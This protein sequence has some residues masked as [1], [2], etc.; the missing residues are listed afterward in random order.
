[1]GEERKERRS[2]LLGDIMLGSISSICVRPGDSPAD[3]YRPARYG[4]PV[5]T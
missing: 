2:F 5:L 3:I 4:F 1:V